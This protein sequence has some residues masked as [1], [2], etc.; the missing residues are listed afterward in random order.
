M[1]SEDDRIFL[2]LICDYIMRTPVWMGEYSTFHILINNIALVIELIF[3][4]KV[5]F[6]QMNPTLHR[7]ARLYPSI[8]IFKE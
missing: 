3:S 8:G 4:V 2:A 1:S 7:D 5:I 6:F